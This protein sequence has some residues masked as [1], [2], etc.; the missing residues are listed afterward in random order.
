MLKMYCFPLLFIFLFLTSLIYSLELPNDIKVADEKKDYRVK[1]SNRH[2]KCID[3][4]LNCDVDNLGIQ[5]DNEFLNCLNNSVKRHINFVTKMK[6]NEM[7]KQTSKVN[8][9]EFYDEV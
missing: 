9:E 7:S 3:V 8:I 1:V 6:K 4:Y 2:L 5:C